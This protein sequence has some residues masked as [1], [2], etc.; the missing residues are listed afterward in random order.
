MSNNKW[1]KYW[2]RQSE[3]CGSD[4]EFDRGITPRT[5]EIEN[6]SNLELLN[7][8][9]PKPSETI[10][11]A[12]CGSGSN[13][14]LLHTKV[15]RLIGMDYSRGA[16]AR[17]ERRI[18]SN[19]IENVKLIRGDLTSPPL[20]ES[21]VDK[22]LCMS[23]LQ[24]LTDAEVRTSF[25]EFKRI[26]KDRGIAILHVKNICSLYLSTLWAAKKAKAI[27]GMKTKQEHV[28]SYRWYVK[29]LESLGFEVLDYNSFN[30]LMIEGMPKRLLQFFQKL[31]L[32]FYD[33]LPLRLGFL[34]RR[35]AE[36]KIKVR[37]MK[38][39]GARSLQSKSI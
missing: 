11:D 9:E 29:E 6:S 1:K 37:I 21:S 34:R 15:K 13:I 22:I 30:L 35:G 8:I 39:S 36:L 10:F 25:V 5:G 14:L 16:L 26:L 17:C 4:F 12:G 32:K 33:R 27:L 18:I 3:Q 24:Y 20:R 19:R 7:F 2:E 28:R 23:V 31:E 38:N